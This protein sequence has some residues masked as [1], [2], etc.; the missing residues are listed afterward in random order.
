MDKLYGQFFEAID[1][2]RRLHVGD[3]FPNMSKS[4]C[5]TLMAIDYY[6]QKK[7]DGVLTVSELAE[8]IHVKPSAVSRT[9]KN[10][11]EQ[12]LIER[13]VNKSDRRNTDIEISDAGR[14]RQQEMKVTM[15]EFVDAV[16]KRI[17]EEDLRKLVEYLNEVCQIAMEEIELRKNK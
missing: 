6:K 4:D 13:T 5:T 2:L 16:L 11:E 9:L 7:S 17:R 8:K 14:K 1:Q 10:L 3:L 12:G 15:E